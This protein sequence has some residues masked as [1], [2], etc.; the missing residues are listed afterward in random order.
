MSVS[1]ESAVEAHQPHSHNCQRQRPSP[2]TTRA[3]NR[4][5]IT[6]THQDKVYD[7]SELSLTEQI[8]CFLIL[9]PLVTLMGLIVYYLVKDG[10]KFETPTFLIDSAKVYPFDI[11]SSNITANWNITVSIG[12]IGDD[13]SPFYYENMEAS[14]LLKNER[15]CSTKIGNLYEDYEGDNLKVVDVFLKSSLASMNRTVAE[16]V[17][18]EKR[19]N[20]VVTFSFE[21]NC[22]GTMYYYSRSETEKKRKMKVLC[23]DLKIRFSANTTSKAGTLVTPHGPIFCDVSVFHCC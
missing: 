13:R 22:I 7:S 12:Y 16:A 8:C 9:L 3:T 2:A 15:V 14:L 11:S 19:E 18:G 20:G 23:K 17:M 21:L 4:R 10:N 5:Q 1:P 6:T